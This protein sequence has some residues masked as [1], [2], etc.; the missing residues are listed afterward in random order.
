MRA[1]V[2]WASGV[3]LICAFACG[4]LWGQASTLPKPRPY[5]ISLPGLELLCVVG[6]P[7][8]AWTTTICSELGGSS[9][10]GGQPSIQGSYEGTSPGRS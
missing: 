5:F 7:E 10:T 8:A 9:P 6:A 2:I 4:L 3:S 1:L